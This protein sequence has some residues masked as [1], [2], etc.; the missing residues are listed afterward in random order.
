MIKKIIY[1]IF[2]LFIFSASVWA[3]NYPVEIPDPATDFTTVDGGS[4]CGGSPCDSDDTIIIEGGTWEAGIRFQNFDG[5]GSYINI[6]NDPS[7]QVVVE[8]TIFLTDCSYTHLRGNNNAGLEGFNSSDPE[9]KNNY[10]IVIHKSGSN[11]RVSGTGDHLKISDVATDGAN[12]F[13]QDAAE[14]NA[15]IWD[16]IEIYN[17]LVSNSN[18]H[19]AYLG[20]NDPDTADNPYLKNLSVHDGI[21]KNTQTEGMEIKGIHPSSDPITVYNIKF[22][23][24]GLDAGVTY[25]EFFYNGLYLGTFFGGAYATVTDCWFENVWGAG[26]NCSEDDS[27]TTS[28]PHTITDCVLLNCG[29][30]ASQN[31]FKSGILLNFK[32]QDVDIEDNIIIQAGGYGV[33]CNVLNAT[34][35]GNEMKRNSIADCPLGEWATQIEGALEEATGDDENIYEANPIDLDCVTVFI[36][37]KDFSDDCI[38][39]EGNPYSCG[40]VFDGTVAIEPGNISEAQIVDGGITIELTISDGSWNA[41][42]DE[43]KATLIAGL[44]AQSD[45]GATDWNTLVRDDAGEWWLEEGSITLDGDTITITLPAFP[46][47]DNT[48]NETIICTIDETLIDSAAENVTATPNITISAWSCEVP[49]APTRSLTTYSICTVETYAGGYLELYTREPITLTVGSGGSYAT[50]ANAFAASITGDIFS[51]VSDIEEDFTPTVDGGF[52]YYYTV[53]GNGHSWT[54]STCEFSADYWYLYDIDF[55]G[56]PPIFSGDFIKLGRIR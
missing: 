49:I 21:I 45:Q 5:N 51:L 47:Y 29:H 10:G 26:I 13:I 39:L 48:T 40:D 19:G 54:C 41:L 33:Y 7:T 36:D 9:D 42:T 2:F 34:Y 16:T 12:F 37:N 18:Y 52:D 4:F 27:D 43:L 56:V 14:S 6:V 22:K 25:N 32:A 1:A 30:G 20:Q 31:N 15:V 53:D 23:D 35:D 17:F 46:T 44:D 38:V 50:M 55:L 11:Y 3:A 28:S 24:T 8:G